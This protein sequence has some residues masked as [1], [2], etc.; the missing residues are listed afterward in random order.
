[1][2]NNLLAS[3]IALTLLSCGE[4]KSEKTKQL[5]KQNQTLKMYD[6]YIKDYNRFVAT[7]DT[8]SMASILNLQYGD[9][10]PMLDSMRIADEKGK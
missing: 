6:A 5:E 9:A 2:K 3:M 7:G 4:Y 8:S 1:M 10:R